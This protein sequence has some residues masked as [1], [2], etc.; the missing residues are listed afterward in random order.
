MLPVDAIGDKFWSWLLKIDEG[1]G[2][3]VAAAGCQHCGGPLHRGDFPRKP[4]C[5]ALVITEPG[6]ARRIGLCC[7]RTG[8]RKRAL[9]PSV[10]YLGRRVYVGAAV[11]LASALADVAMAAAKI[12]EQTGIPARTVRRWQAW[13]KAGF[14]SSR[15]FREQ[16]G[17]FMPPLAEAELPGTLLERF[18]LPGEDGQVAMVRTAAFLAPLTTASVVDGARFVRL[19]PAH[20][21]EGAGSLES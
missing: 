1:I 9:P 11:L 10:R 12:V 15:L 5:G 17:R 7:G 18:T 20:A 21:E 14:L 16:G 8:C 6:W 19:D 4:R 3:R 2:A 13:W